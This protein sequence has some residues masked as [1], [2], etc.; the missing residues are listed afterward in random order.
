M[1]V[2]VFLSHASIDKPFVT[3]I[4]HGLEDGGDIKCWLDEGEI[5]FGQN[6]AAQINEG[7]RRS[8]LLLLFLSPDSMKS[9]WVEEEWT[10]K[11]WSGV[12][13]KETHLIP[14]LIR[15]CQL[16]SLLQNKKYIDL[17]TNQLEG[18][19]QLKTAVLRRKP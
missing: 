10:A 19:R 15:D 6:I 3:D 12:N 16:P 1:P 5:D 4:K 8:D 7:L 9:N 14:V 18:M 2:N 13:S 11:Y 17:R